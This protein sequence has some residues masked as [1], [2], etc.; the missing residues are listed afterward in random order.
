MIRTYIVNQKDELL[1]DN[2]SISKAV[3][4]KSSV[5]YNTGR[6]YYFS[7]VVKDENYKLEVSKI[8]SSLLV[9]DTVLIKYS[10]EDPSVAKVIDFK[11]MKKFK[12]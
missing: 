11:F 7:Y 1:S 10:L 9:G 12:I 4:T 3:Y 2:V 5:I 8:K 6:V